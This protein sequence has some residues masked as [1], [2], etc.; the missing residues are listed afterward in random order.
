MR[1]LHVDSGHEMRGGQWQVLRL[2]QGLGTEN[3]LLAPAESPLLRAAQASGLHAQPLSMLSLAT[4]SRQ[5]DLVHAHC[6]RSHTWSAAASPA[7]LVV[8]RRVAFPV[9]HSFLSR[10][11]YRRPSRFLAVS[12][13]VKQ[14]LVDAE[15]P[16]ARI[17]VVYDGVD[18]PDSTASGDLVLAPA[19][20]DAMKGSDLVR[21]AARLA[22]VSVCFSDNLERDL[23]KAAVFVYVTRSEGLGSAALLAM[24]YGVPAVASGIGGLPEIVHHQKNGLLVENDPDAIAAAIR[25]CLERRCE[26]G[27]AARKTVEERFSL[28]HMVEGTREVY[29]Q[30]LAC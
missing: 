30:V 26:W 19:T 7:P 25:V 20:A 17:S 22:G 11:K 15:V 3:T 9:G 6:A 23:P 13:H 10:W 4:L 2:L 14:A 24:A 16:E 21:E 1:V 29:S 18:L 12:E 8:S 5:S 28:R 27:S